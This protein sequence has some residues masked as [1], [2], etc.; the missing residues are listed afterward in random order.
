MMDRQSNDRVGCGYP[1]QENEIWLDGHTVN[2]VETDR[3]LS[4]QFGRRR[5]LLAS[6][7]QVKWTNS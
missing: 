4:T 7:L 1:I 3:F 2:P 5:L 6:H